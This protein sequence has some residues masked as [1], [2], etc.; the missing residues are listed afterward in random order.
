M[1][2][3]F[4]FFLACVI[5]QSFV[6]L[7]GGNSWDRSGGSVGNSG[8]T[9]T[10]LPASFDT[11]FYSGSQSAFRLYMFIKSTQNITYTMTLNGVTTASKKITNSSTITSRTVGNFTSIVGY[12]KITITISGKVSLTT[13]VVEKFDLRG[14]FTD[15][16]YVTDSS[17]FYWGRRGPSCHLSMNG[18]ISSKV[19][20]FYS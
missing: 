16:T 2:K 7:T 19:Q 15:L 13:G 3:I 20:Y 9:F 1:Q 8:Y 5:S 14:T 12:N 4:I 11:Y 10:K 18:I 17:W 6:L